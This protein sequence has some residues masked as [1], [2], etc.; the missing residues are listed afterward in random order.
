MAGADPLR[1]RRGRETY[2]IERPA[3]AAP[4]DMKDPF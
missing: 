3:D 1:L 2:W 4:A